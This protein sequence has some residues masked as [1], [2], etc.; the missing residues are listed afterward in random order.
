MS[1]QITVNLPPLAELQQARQEVAAAIPAKA[2]EEAEEVESRIIRQSD[3]DTTMA[4]ARTRIDI[5]RTLRDALGKQTCLPP[6]RVET[7][8]FAGITKLFAM[9]V[10]LYPAL[11]SLQKA[12]KYVTQVCNAA[13]HAQ[14]VSDRQAEEALALGAEILAALQAFERGDLLP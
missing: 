7:I 4:L 3:E 12:F 1:N 6:E 9:A 13:I 8:K 10:E 2:K 14:R 5:E 11:Q